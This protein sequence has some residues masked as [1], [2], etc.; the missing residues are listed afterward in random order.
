MA[1]IGPGQ[2]RTLRRTVFGNGR[3]GRHPVG[4]RGVLA[5]WRVTAV[6]KAWPD[7]PG[8]HR[9]ACAGV[10]ALVLF[11]EVVEADVFEGLFGDFFRC[12]R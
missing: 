4:I 2:C 12:R 10:G 1:S 9:S 6:V 11:G 7:L 5:G 3:R 8:Q